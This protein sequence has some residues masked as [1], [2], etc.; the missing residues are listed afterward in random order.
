MAAVRIGLPA[1]YA[2]TAAGMPEQCLLKAFHHIFGAP[3]CQPFPGVISSN[4]C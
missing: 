2:V 3:V 1:L 4:N